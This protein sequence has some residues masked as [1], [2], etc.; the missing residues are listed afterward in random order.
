[1]KWLF[2]PLLG[3]GTFGAMGSLTG[4]CTEKAPDKPVT[5]SYIFQ[6]PGF[7]GPGCG[8]NFSCE[9]GAYNRTKD[10][11]TAVQGFCGPV[12]GITFGC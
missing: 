4:C 5:C 3:V 8:K 1:M 11:C 9:S 6:C 10:N 7:S 2:Y 12:C